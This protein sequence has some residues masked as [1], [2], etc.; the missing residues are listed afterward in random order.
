MVVGVAGC[1]SPPAPGPPSGAD[2][3]TSHTRS[4]D[5]ANIARA[6]SALPPGYEM[7]DLAAGSSPARLWGFGDRWSA[8]PAECAVLAD[9]V[10]AGP[11]R[12][13]SASGPGGIVYAAVGAGAPPDPALPGRCAHWTLSAGHTT[14]TVARTGAPAI[15]GAMTVAM[16]TV[17]TTVVEGGTE[18]RSDADTVTAYLDGEAVFVTVVTDPGRPAPPLDHAFTAHLLVETVSALRG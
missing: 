10:T 17:A 2:T 18:T 5:P 15:D 7:A 4:I 13:W 14:G 12:G 3:A 16:S 9:P 6:L 8:Q 11:L 1:G